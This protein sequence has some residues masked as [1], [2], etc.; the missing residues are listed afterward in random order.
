MTEIIHKEL[1]YITH[2]ALLRIFNFVDVWIENG[3]LIL[4]LK[5]APQIMPV[6]KAQALSYLKV[7]NADLAIVVNFGAGSLETERMPKRDGQRH[8]PDPVHDGRWR[9]RGGRR[10]DRQW[11][12]RGPAREL[13]RGG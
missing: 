11:S 3:K 4:E 10:G 7:T 6:Y 5:V 8:K 13:V 9:A 1:S 12:D 2:G